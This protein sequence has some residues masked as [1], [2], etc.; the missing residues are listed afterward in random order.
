LLPTEKADLVIDSMDDRVIE[1][2]DGPMTWGEWKKRNPV[3]V[4]SR[5]TKG[6]D[7]PNKIKTRTDQG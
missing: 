4:P 3:Q 5:R 6:K 1:T 7:L 2:P